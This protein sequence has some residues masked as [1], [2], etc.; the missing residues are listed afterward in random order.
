MGK[1]DKLSSNQSF[2]SFSWDNKSYWLLSLLHIHLAELLNAAEYGS[3]SV[4]LP[5]NVA[6]DLLPGLGS[7]NVLLVKLWPI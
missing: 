6:V 5:K 3:F 7:M 2:S 1:T 4:G